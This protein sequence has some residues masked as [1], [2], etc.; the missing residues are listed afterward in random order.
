[1]PT[2]FSAAIL[3]RC[4]QSNFNINKNFPLFSQTQTMNIYVRLIVLVLFAG[5]VL[6]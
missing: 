4:Y 2:T 3:L 5:L 6:G 1:M